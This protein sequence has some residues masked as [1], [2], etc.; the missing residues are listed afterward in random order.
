[1]L[2]FIKTNSS[3]I[4]TNS[5][6]TQI[7]NS[8]IK[9]LPLQDTLTFTVT[10]ETNMKRL[11]LKRPIQA[12]FPTLDI[13]KVLILGKIKPMLTKLTS[14][15]DPKRLDSSLIL[16]IRWDQR[17]TENLKFSERFHCLIKTTTSD[18]SIMNGSISP[19]VNFNINFKQNHIF[20]NSLV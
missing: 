19:Q 14:S 9:D 11:S 10:L 16:K 12:D 7:N 18:I 13:L 15:A 1:M 5:S 17:N 3:F 2:S 8:L 6:S 20:L 4:K